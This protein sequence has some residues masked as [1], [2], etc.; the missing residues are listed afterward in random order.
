MSLDLAHKKLGWPSRDEIFKPS[1]EGVQVFSRLAQDKIGGAIARQPDG[2]GARV[3]ILAANSAASETE[4][5]LAVV[6]EFQR[7]ITDKTLREMQKLAWNFSRCPMLVT[8]EPHL[9]R[10]WTCCEPPTEEEFLLPEPVQQLKSSE[11]A[12]SD[13]LAV[14]ATQALHWV[15]LVSGQFFKEN[16]SR[17]R[18]DQRADQLLLENL[19]FVRE[20][21]RKKGLKDDDVCHDLLAR[22]IFIQFL[23]DRK[24]SSGNAALNEN[25]LKRLYAEKVLKKE[26]KHF[27]SILADYD[28]SYHLFYW[29]NERFNGDLFPGKGDTEAEREE[30]W[31]AEKRVVEKKHLEVLELFVSGRLDMP[32]GQRCLWRQYAFDAI[33]LEFISSIYEAFVTERARA[34]GIYY[35]PPHLVDFTLDRVLPWDGEEWNLK[36]LDPACGSGVF[37]VKSFQRLVHRWKKANPKQVLRAD[38]LRGL[39]ENNL[40]GVDKDPHAV[41]VASFSLYLAMCDEI[42]PKHYWTQIHFPQMRERRLIHADFFREDCAGFQTN[43]DAGSYDLVVGN[44]PWGEELMTNAANDWANNK[45]HNWPVANNGIGTLFLPKSAA[46][47]KVTGKVAMIQSA[48]SLLFNRSGPACEFREKFFSAFDIEQVVN[49]SALRFEIFKKKK[50]SAQNAVSPPCIVVFNPKL[51]S[52]NR[53]LYISPKVMEENGEESAIIVEPADVKDIHPVDAA[54]DSA[55]WIALMW[56]NGR[57]LAL[58]R[59]LATFRSLESLEKEGR[60]KCCEGIIRGKNP[61]FRK[62]Y[63]WLLEKPILEDD[64]F[65]QNRSLY[66]F[67][68]DLPPNKDALAE[69]QKKEKTFCPP[70]LLIKQGWSVKAKRFQARQVVPNSRGEGAICTQGFFFLF[71]KRRKSRP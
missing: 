39:L 11:L 14:R 3:G 8:I 44:A 25:T 54:K 56:G 43:K 71:L 59:R 60:L 55:V 29:L 48:S 26:H 21:L 17:F 9:L 6:C 27:A 1:G 7:S 64:E 62:E 23:F 28:E 45:E 42:D 10:I 33:P 18:R 24:D 63:K 16:A 47:T 40:F 69:R 20:E 53:I 5:P 37:L 70:Q 15:N 35:T 52:G 30:A 19:R 31:Q 57:D 49:L 58:V 38:T 2:S 36:V 65:P 50:S 67:A 46:L 61:K 12:K 34:G 68:D 66:L 4:P 22:V 13:S 32:K 41:R 51:Q